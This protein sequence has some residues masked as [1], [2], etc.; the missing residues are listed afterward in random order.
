[1]EVD[2]HGNEV[3]AKKGKKKKSRKSNKWVTKKY[4][5]SVVRIDTKDK[6]EVDLYKRNGMVFNPIPKVYIAR[7]GTVRPLD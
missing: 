2:K 6:H 4:K 1:V 3:K 7:Q 5:I